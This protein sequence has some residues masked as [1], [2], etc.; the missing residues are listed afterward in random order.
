MLHDRD[1]RLERTGMVARDT[2]GAEVFS[3]QAGEF[4]LTI[5]TAAVISPI[6]TI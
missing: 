3:N 5:P 1:L 2:R 6:E 4:V